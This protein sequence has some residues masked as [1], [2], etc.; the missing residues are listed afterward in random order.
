[1]KTF[2]GILRCWSSVAKKQKKP[3]KAFYF[4]Q[5]LFSSAGTAGLE[6]VT[7]CVTGSRSNQL[8]YAPNSSFKIMPY[9]GRDSNPRPQRYEC[10]ALTN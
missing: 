9:Q 2:C 4:G 5:D 10:C 8:S 7:Y 1:M 3:G 6:P